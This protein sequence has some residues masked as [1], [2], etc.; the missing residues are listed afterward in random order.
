MLNRDAAAKKVVIIGG[1]FGGINAA[2]RL[3]NKKEVFFSLVDRRNHHL[4]QPL[5][6][7]VAT[8]GL[9]P[10]EI[11]MPIR[12]VIARYDNGEVFLG[13][14][15]AV[16][17]AERTITTDFGSLSYD[18]LVMACGANHSYFGH[19]EWEE[20]APGLKT[21]EQATEIRRR[22][23]TALELAEREKDQEVKHTLLTF[24]V[25]GGGPTGV[26]L[27]GTLGEITRYA[28]SRDFDHIDPGRTRIILIEAGP[29]ILPTFSEELSRKAARNLEELGVT[30]WTDSRVTEVNATGVTVGTET[31]KTA[32]VLWAAGVR[33]SALNRLLG[34]PLDKQGRV[35]VEADLSLKDHPEVF[36]IGDQASCVDERGMALPGL[37]PVAIQQGI[38]VAKNILADLQNR[39]RRPFHYFDKGQMATI[40][41]RR[42]VVQTKRLRFSGF[43][44]WLAWLLVH[45]YYLIGFRNRVIVLI[46]WAWA[47]LTF[48]RGAQ[49]ILQKEW[50]S[51]PV[52]VKTSAR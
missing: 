6:Y 17:L 11:A 49:L 19:D 52:S 32:T 13:N 38:A 29:R 48:K 50:R 41:R 42:A 4:F 34:V 44:A 12:T 28:L 23:L 5:L 27:A 8:A 47:Y 7:Q 14:V 10:G 39:P 2:K 43:L 9:S 35:V 51:H 18:Y 22:I 31:L 16:N 46:Q 33:P 30:V 1:G 26:E 3:G 40:G 20:F 45:I 21:L 25:V 15:D 37:A 36:V 24:V